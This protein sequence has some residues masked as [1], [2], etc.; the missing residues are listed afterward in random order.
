MPNYCYNKLTIVGSAEDVDRFVSGA[1]GHCPKTGRDSCLLFERFV[2]LGEDS[3]QGE[4]DAWSVKWG[5]FHEQITQHSKGTATYLFTTAWG[6]PNKFL[7]GASTLFPRLLFLYS[8]GEDSP[9]RGRRMLKNAVVDFVAEG[10]K[11][12]SHGERKSVDYISDEGD[13]AT[14]YEKWQRAYL[15][16]HDVWVSDATFLQAVQAALKDEPEKELT[17]RP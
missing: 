6:P 14:A 2:A 10:E 12:K 4:I 15:D 17:T 16:S 9:C 5:A 8:Y 13:R 11:P 3:Q 1:A 7:K